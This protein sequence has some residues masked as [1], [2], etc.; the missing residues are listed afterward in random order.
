MLARR[1]AVA[2]AAVAVALAACGPDQCPMQAAY[3]DPAQ[4]S[5]PA[6]C[7]V[8]GETYSFTVPLCE[9]CQYTSP[10]CEADLV[11]SNTVQLAT[12]WQVCSE[13]QGCAFPGSEPICYFPRCT[14]TVPSAGTYTISYVTMDDQGVIQTPSFEVVFG[15]GT[16]TCG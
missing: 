10:N 2:G 3:V 7:S 11:G 15:A 8:S 9:T 12:Q 13:N 5:F 4:A 6:S 14:V 1:L 16:N